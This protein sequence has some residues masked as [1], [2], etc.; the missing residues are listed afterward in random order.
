MKISK[1]SKIPSNPD[2]VAIMPGSGARVSMR[3]GIG[4]TLQLS[5]ET[6]WK[7]P[8]QITL[9]WDGTR[10]LWTSTMKAGFVNG[11]CPVVISTAGSDANPANWQQFGINPLTGE[12]F[13]SAWVFN[14]AAPA[15]APATTVWLPL[16]SNPLIDLSWYNIGSD[17]ATA[18]NAVPQF[19][20]NLGVTPATP[21]DPDDPDQSAGAPPPAG[22][23]LLR[24]C[25]L[26]LHQ[27]HVALTSQITLAPG[28]VTGESNVSQ[29]LGLTQ[30]DPSDTLK[31]YAQAGAFSPEDAI[32]AGIDP[33]TGDYTEPAYDEILIGTA[34]LLSPP[35]TEPYSMPDQT[36]QPYVSHSLFWNLF[37]AQPEFQPT[38]AEATDAFGQLAQ[39]TSVLGAG[40]GSVA[41]NYITS[42]LT[43]A[44]QAATNILV[45]QSMA[46]SF[47]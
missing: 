42:S 32:A 10:Q 34:Y 1:L 28:I 12:P 9:L 30:I 13:F 16:Y 15:I 21:I 36:W 45:A 5:P 27:P 47:W 11:E 18:Q 44:Y 4:R 23:R 41:I 26:I 33:S 35:N 39:L 40:A 7:H 17:D 20:L 22:N 31:M 46:G 43:D 14:N 19:F 3:G 29:T 25:D 37:W 38:P 6:G 24:A 2:A 8:W